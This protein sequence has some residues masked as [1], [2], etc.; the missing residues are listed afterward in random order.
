MLQA[1]IKGRSFLFADL[2]WYSRSVTIAVVMAGSGNA[3]ESSLLSPCPS[4]A[5]CRA[6][7]RLVGH[8]GDSFLGD[9][10]DSDWPSGC[11]YCDDDVDGCTTGAWLNTHSTGSA[12]GGAQPYC[13]Y[14][15]TPLVQGK[16]VFVGDSD[17]EYDLS[18]LSRL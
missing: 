12:N 4:L 18:L 9:E 3:R 8:Y 1:P 13:S 14:D 16:T 5:S 7:L 11:Y 17:I 10:D 2:V 15:F 6:G